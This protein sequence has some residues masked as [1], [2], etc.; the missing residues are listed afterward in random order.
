MSDYLVHLQHVSKT[1]AKK[2]ILKQVSIAIMKGDSIAF[3]GQNGAGKST[4]LRIIGGLTKPT[5]G[6]VTYPEPLSISYIPER[7]P[8]MN[9]SA[10]Q[11]IDHMGRIE[12]LGKVEIAA[13]SQALFE[14]FYMESMQ[15]VP[16]KNLSKGTLQKVAVIQALL[17]K[18][19]MLLLDEPLSGQ[20]IESQDVFVAAVN[21]LNQEGVAIVMSCHE[22]FLIHQ[23]SK[24]VFAVENGTL[25]PLSL[26]DFSLEEQVI[27]QFSAL[28]AQIQLPI[29]VEQLAHQV[30]KKGNILKIKA[31]RQTSSAIIIE[32][33]NNNWELR[34]IC[35]ENN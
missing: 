15:S 11:Y 19:A 27:L 10:A 28:D 35:H 31:S 16:M 34:E 9:I 18:P 14:R 23:I 26:E 1:L 12:G 32:M 8:K 33:L 21:Q 29:K 30:E 13:K 22:K 25:K 4:L 6:T 24:K 7:F 20:D 17:T 3:V 5:S 2:D